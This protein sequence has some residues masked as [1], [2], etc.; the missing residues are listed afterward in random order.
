M[1]CKPNDPISSIN[2]LISQFT[3]IENVPKPYK[4]EPK[5]RTLQNTFTPKVIDYITNLV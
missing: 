4:G 3:L 1:Y 2:E 5:K